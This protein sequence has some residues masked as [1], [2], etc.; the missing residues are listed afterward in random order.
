MEGAEKMQSN[1]KPLKSQ[2]AI[3]C[4]KAAILLCSLKSF[5]N[6]H[7]TTSI[8]DQGEQEMMMR[9]IGDLKMELARERFKSKRIRLCGLMEVILQVTVMKRE[10]GK[11]WWGN[12]ATVCNTL[13]PLKALIRRRG[14]K[15]N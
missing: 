3:R 2:V 12:H 4:A 10:I 11:A 7:L 6:H 13:T 15:I 9:E 5:P 8:D 1:D 14:K